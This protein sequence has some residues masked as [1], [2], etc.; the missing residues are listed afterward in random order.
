[1]RDFLAVVGL[2]A[3]LAALTSYLGLL[4]P[5]DWLFM[6]RCALHALGL[7]LEGV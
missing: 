4:T 5:Q 1:M 3:L 6:A 7:V 2:L